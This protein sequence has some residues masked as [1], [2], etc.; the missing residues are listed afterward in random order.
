LTKKGLNEHKY[1]N[2]VRFNKMVI[3]KI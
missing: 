1:K 3:I 2:T